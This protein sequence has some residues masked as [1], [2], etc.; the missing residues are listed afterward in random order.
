MS[1]YIQDL[2]NIKTIKSLAAGVGVTLLATV[3]FSLLAGGIVYFSPLNDSCLLLCAALVEIFSALAGGFTAARLNGS[4]GLI[5][6]LL[7]GVIA[8]VI[9]IPGSSNS[10][11]ALI[12][13]PSLLI[14]GAVGGIAGRN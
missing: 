13:L 7:C 6:G 4:R 11:P 14:P 10:L 9:L 1:A 8:A 12:S 5:T 3:L 2:F